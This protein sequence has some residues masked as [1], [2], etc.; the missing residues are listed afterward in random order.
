M[1]IDMHLSGYAVLDKKVVKIG[2]SAHVTLPVDW[3]GKRVKVI[4]SEPVGDI[5]E[6][7]ESQ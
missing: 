3:I 4:L 7:T 5:E 6:E 2:N 1:K